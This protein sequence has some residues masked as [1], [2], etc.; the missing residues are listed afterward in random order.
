[1][2]KRTFKYKFWLGPSTSAEGVVE[3]VDLTTD[4]KGY[5]LL[6]LGPTSDGRAVDTT[7]VGT[8]AHIDLAAIEHNLSRGVGGAQLTLGDMIM[9][10]ADAGARWDALAER[11]IEALVRDGVIQDSAD[12][13]GI[14]D[15]QFEL[16]P[17]GELCIFVE[18]RGHRIEML[19]VQPEWIW[20]DQ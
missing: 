18:F 15:E 6:N 12:G 4:R 13:A 20:R 17:S 8:D 16:R 14:P 3:E 2:G 1:M 19:F 9:L 5:K 7:V 10:R 11:A